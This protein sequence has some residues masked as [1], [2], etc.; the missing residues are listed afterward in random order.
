MTRDGNAKIRFLLKRTI[1][2]FLR[3]LRPF[4]GRSLRRLPAIT[5]ALALAACERGFETGEEDGSGGEA[6]PATVADWP[7]FRGDPEM[8]GVSP[9]SIAPPLR[10]AWKYEP[11]VAEGKRRPPIDA[12]PVVA[13]GRVFVGSQDGNVHALDLADG[14]LAWTFQ[15]D[16]PVIAPAAAL[17]DRVFVGDTHGFVYALSAADGEELWRFETGGKIEGGINTLEREGEPTRVFV[18][19]HDY[20]LYCLD[21][22]DGKELW[23]GETGN[24]VVATPSLVRSG[25]GRV[26]LAFGGCDGL[27]H[28]LPA[29]GKGG[30][31]EIEI[32][33][34]VAN[35]SAVRD[36][37]CYVA[38]NGGEVLAIDI[39]SGETAWKTA[40][41]NEFTA[42]PAVDET[43]LYV[44]GPDKR[45][46]AYDRV[47]GEEAWAF[48]AP[49]A[50]SSSP[51][52]SGGTIWQGGMDGR[53]YAVNREDGTESWSYDL[54]TQIKAS[55]AAS[56]GTLVVCGEDGVVYAFRK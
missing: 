4:P 39:A 7:L 2:P 25:D 5:L 51:L 38:H 41:G 6:A 28:I 22:A 9:E 31:R 29:D 48:V 53:L 10:A 52:V 33:A 55:P 34:Y 26:D 54:G 44:A 20:F 47:T 23:K 40:T 50:L 49:R 12:T 37:I 36:G 16:G 43:R 24:Y 8:R 18:G 56:R 17:G 3:F 1:R 14:S 46:V 15:A 27:L 13:G 32:G 42:S 11:P 45:L 19:S 35:S 30:K 21:A